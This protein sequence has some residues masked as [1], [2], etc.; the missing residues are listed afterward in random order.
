MAAPKAA[1]ATVSG[2]VRPVR[3]QRGELPVWR[4]RDA[5][6]RGGRGVERAMEECDV[7]PAPRARVGSGAAGVGPYG[8]RDRASVGFPVGTQLVWVMD[9]PFI[10]LESLRTVGVGG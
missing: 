1:G 8:S 5:E 6:D 9:V 4:P 2:R 3:L 10:E 7:G